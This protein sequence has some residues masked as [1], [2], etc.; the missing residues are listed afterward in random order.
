MKLMK[1][2]LTASALLFLASC[3][4]LINPPV[5]RVWDFSL[6]VSDSQGHLIPH[7]K[8][9]LDG[10]TTESNDYGWFYAAVSEKPCHVFSVEKE[11]F[12]PTGDQNICL[13]RATR[14]P[15]KLEFIAPPV[16]RL[17]INGKLFYQ[18]GKP[19]RWKGVTAFGLQN[20][21]CKG[22][23]IQP[24]LNAFP[25]FNTL[26]VFYYVEWTDTGWLRPTDSCM[27]D[28]LN[29]VGLRGWY[30]EMVAFTGF[31]PT[32]EAQV[33]TDHLF[34]EFNN[35][36][37]LMIELVNEPGVGDKVDPAPLRVPQTDILWTDGITRPLHRGLY[38]TPHTAR[39]A[40]WP[41]RAH[42]LMEYWGGGGPEAPTDPPFREPAVAD[43]PIRPDQ[44]GYVASDYEA[45]FGV[46]S[47]MGAGAT[48]HFESG[49]YGQPPTAQEAVCAAAALKALDYFPADATLG[50][51]SR[52]DEAGATSRTYQVGPYIVRVRPTSGEILIRP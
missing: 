41:R 20:R 44:A 1:R 43:E 33:I 29:Y 17:V 32:S 21:F 3:G 27:H 45:Y 13:T 25:G 42:D 7:A 18:D 46:A 51:Y 2:F 12:K 5:A 6:S 36:T 10:N 8:V 22:E 35:Q 24:F 16:T 49:K 15:V 31:M 28:F 26:R 30:V 48:F 52:I 11:G 47:I 38:L 40:D 23:D 50:P 39:D 4:P 19:W 37:N 14:V 34:S 9:T